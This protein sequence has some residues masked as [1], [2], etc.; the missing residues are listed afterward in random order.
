MQRGP[1]QSAVHGVRAVPGSAVAGNADSKVVPRSPL[2]QITYLP[3]AD[4]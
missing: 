3:G 2:I 4:P 1:G